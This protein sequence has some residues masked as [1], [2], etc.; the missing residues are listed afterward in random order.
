MS[1]DLNQT[2]R[3]ARLTTPLGENVLVLTGFDAVEGLSEL[4]EYRIDA[5]SES[6]APD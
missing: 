6:V 4:F 2:G 1:A 3:V 5:L